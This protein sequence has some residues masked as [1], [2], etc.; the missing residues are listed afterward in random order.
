MGPQ[1]EF[2]K[3][4]KSQN[5]KLVNYKHMKDALKIEQ[6]PAKI[7]PSRWDHCNRLIHCETLHFNIL[8]FI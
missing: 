7:F 3:K 1:E 2:L 8:G 5:D 6:S 4:I